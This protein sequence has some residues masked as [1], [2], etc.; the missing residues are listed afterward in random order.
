[1]NLSLKTGGKITENIIT[2]I[3]NSTSSSSSRNPKINTEFALSDIQIQVISYL[4]QKEESISKNEDIFVQS[5]T[6]SGKSLSYIIPLLASI[7]DEIDHD[8]GNYNNSIISYSKSVGDP[9]SPNSLIITPTREL[10]VQTFNTIQSIL[11]FSNLKY[12]FINFIIFPPQ[13]KSPRK[14]CKLIIFFYE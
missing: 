13:K 1:M 7:Y 5:P 10:C 11:N 6:G 4:M 8:D 9:I 12:D 3:Q 14:I 2:G